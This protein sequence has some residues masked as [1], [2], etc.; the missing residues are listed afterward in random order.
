MTTSYFQDDK[1]EESMR[2]LFK[3]AKK[4]KE[5]RSGIDGYL[6]VSGKSIQFELKTTAD[7]KCNVTTVRDLGPEHIKKW[8]DKHWL[9]GFYSGDKI[10]YKYGTP[11]Q[12]SPWIKR[13]EIYIAPDFELANIT[14]ERLT[15]E[16]LYKVLGE[17]E[18]YTI[19]EAKILHKRQLTVIQY[20]ELQDK[21]N[22]YSPNAMLKI[23]KLRAK[24]LIERGS[25]LN[26]PH[27][28]GSYFS[29]WA[30][31]DNNHAEKLKELVLQSIAT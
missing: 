14:Y 12:M 27:I 28:P 9:I 8:K 19:E 13:K 23:F 25:T 22:F 16:D 3:L 6:K 1:R 31:I 5:G 4:K 11:A 24:Y 21:G 2:K 18:H 20:K 17:K 29:S 10:I 15:L 30:T 26:N 7:K